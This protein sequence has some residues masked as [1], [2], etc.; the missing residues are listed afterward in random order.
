MP[1]SSPTDLADIELIVFDVDGV[2]TDGT[3]HI[4]PDGGQSKSF[5]LRDGLAI[6]QARKAGLEVAI[7]S[8]RADDAT[9]HRM[10]RLGVEL[11]IR[12]SKDKGADVTKLA[13]QAGVALANTAFV[14]DDLLDLPAMRRVGLAMCPAD[15]AEDVRQRVHRV[16]QTPGGYGV[17][18][19][20]IEAIL[21]ARGLWEGIVHRL[22]GEA[23]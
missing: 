13:K 21:K 2:L 12:G 7:C 1:D 15:A 20:A 18:R 3:L 11:V 22:S 16:L 23:E 19:E 9:L 14:G 4:H 5:H 6:V 17:A 10:N 8:G